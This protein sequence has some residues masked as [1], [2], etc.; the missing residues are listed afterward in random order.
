MLRWIFP[1]PARP[2]LDLGRGRLT[3][4]RSEECD[5]SLPGTEISRQHAEI[6]RD[7]PVSIVRDLGSRNGVFVGGVRHQ[8]APLELDDV[9]RIGEW[10]GLVVP[11]E[12]APVPALGRIAGKVLGGPRLA[13]ALMLGLRGAK[14]DLPI[15]IEGET[16]SGKELTARA[17]HELSGRTGPFIGV[18]C[19]AL[20]ESLAEAELF[21]Y[22]R[23]AFTGADRASNGFF[24]AANGGTLLLD[25][26]TDLPLALQA[27][28]LRV[29]EERQVVPLGESVPVPVDLRIIAA[30]QRPLAEAVADKQFRAD[31]FARLNGVAISLPPLRA[32]REDI[33]FVFLELLKAHSGGRPPEVEHRLVEAL[34]LYDWPF[35]LRELDLVVRR[36]LVLYG[37]ERLLKRSFLPQS[38]TA[39]VDSKGMPLP[40]DREQDELS[41]LVA[42]LRKHRGNVAKAAAAVGISRQRAYRLMEGRGGVDLDDLRGA[43]GTGQGATN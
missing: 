12:V 39:A 11:S 8:E 36:L 6:R 40:A 23:G 7:G 31:L 15:L 10:I 21:G 3:L 13:A 34:A 19:A 22:R 43:S 41:R 2:T 17:L 29:I 18:N 28:L 14:S 30:T 42:Q 9:I 27:K 32:R 16:G 38:L 35:N 5:V 20:P 1:D 25:E 24:R 4:G 26:L 37:H 33:P